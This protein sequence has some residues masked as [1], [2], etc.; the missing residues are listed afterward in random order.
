MANDY[1]KDLPEDIGFGMIMKS[2]K[3]EGKR[4]VYIV[5]WAGMKSEDFTSEVIDDVRSS[6]IDGLKEDNNPFVKSLISQMKEYG[7]GFG[8]RYVNEH[9]EVLC[10]I[11]ISPNELL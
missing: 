9:N 6:T 2:C 4:I 1:N 3:V 11:T 7:Y 10:D 5:E 8:Y